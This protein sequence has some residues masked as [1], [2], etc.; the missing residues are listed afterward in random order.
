M[1]SRRSPERFHFQAGVV[2]DYNFPSYQA[3]VI[4]CLLSRILFESRAIFFDWGEGTEV[5]ERKNFR[6]AVRRRGKISQLAP[7]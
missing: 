4:R 7:I 5:R 1:H 2:G 3:A 6:H